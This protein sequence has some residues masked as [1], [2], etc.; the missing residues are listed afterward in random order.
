MTTATNQ[1]INR[2][3]ALVAAVL[4]DAPD[5]AA[6]MTV[7]E[8]QNRTAA[9]V[10]PPTV[11]AQADALTKRGIAERSNT[12]PA[13]YRAAPDAEADVTNRAFLDALA[14]AREVLGI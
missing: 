13:R 12:R 14:E 8:I 6:W 5:N 10:S 11:R 9:P 7:G 3:T 2:T 4:L 1:V